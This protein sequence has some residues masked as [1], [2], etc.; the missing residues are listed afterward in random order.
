MFHDAVKARDAKL[1][2]RILDRIETV[3]DLV[4]GKNLNSLDAAGLHKA[5]EE[6]AVLLQTAAP[7]LKLKK[8]AVG[9]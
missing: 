5:G 2:K 3:E 9:D 1:D 8:P 6:L 4:K 7:K